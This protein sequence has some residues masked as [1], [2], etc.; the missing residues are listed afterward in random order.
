MCRRISCKLVVSSVEFRRLAT[1]RNVEELTET[2]GVELL[3]KRVF[4]DRYHI[5]PIEKSIWIL[6]K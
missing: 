2:V 4:D 1:I 5:D 3:P 6:E